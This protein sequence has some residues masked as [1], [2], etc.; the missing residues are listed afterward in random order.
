MNSHPETLADLELGDSAI[1]A[2]VHGDHAYRRR[3]FDLGFTPGTRVRVDLASPLGDPRSYRL[4]D[5][6]IA[7]RMEDARSVTVAR[8]SAWI[9]PAEAMLRL[10]RRSAAT[11]AARQTRRRPIV[12][13]AGNPNTGK[14]TI[15]NALTGMR[16]HIGNWPGK[17]V[18]RATGSF[19]FEEQL[20]DLVDLPGTYSLL[21][22]SPEEKIARGFLVFEPPDC[23]VA[24]ADAARLERNLNLALQVMEITDRVVL[25]LNLVDEAEAFGIEI[26]HHALE[27]HLGVPVVPTVARSGHGLDQLRAVMARVATG[28]L[29]P[30]PAVLSPP[31]SIA[32]AANELARRISAANPSFPCPAWAAARLLDGSDPALSSELA[33]RLGLVEPCSAG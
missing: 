2:A 32:G 29:R 4:R 18:A 10:T 27:Q 28:E 6:A 25:C 33:V 16:Q 17:T 13:L 8:G 3:L 21:A 14:S 9:A 11:A 15:F 22:M 5:S 30:E 24:V 7:L 19:R 20:F 26:D 31:P 1:V 12:A 23:T